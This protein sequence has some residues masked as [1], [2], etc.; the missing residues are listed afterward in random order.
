ME[1]HQRLRQW[2]V[3]RGLT[4]EQLCEQ[5]GISQPALSGFETGRHRLTLEFARLVAHACCVDADE[6]DALRKTAEKA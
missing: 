5:I 3:D 1:P 6:W 2:R 4:Q